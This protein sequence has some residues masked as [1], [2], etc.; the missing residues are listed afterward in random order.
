[1]PVVHCAMTGVPIRS[2]PAILIP[3]APAPNALGN[4]VR[5]TLAGCAH[6]ITD[7]GRTGLFSPFTLPDR[8]SVV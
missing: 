3:L 1:M 2:G 6:A 5:P 8:K 4:R 7:G